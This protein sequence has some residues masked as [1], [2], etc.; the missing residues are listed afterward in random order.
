MPIV[1]YGESVFQSVRGI[2]LLDVIRRYCPG[3]E[4]RRQKR[5]YVGLCP[6]H[7]E[8]TPSFTISPDKNLFYCFGCGA[9]GDAV[10]FVVQLLRLSPLEAARQIAADFGL[11]PADGGTLSREAPEKLAEAR[12][13][14]KLERA[15]VERLEVEINRTHQAVCLLLR[16]ATATLARTLAQRDAETVEQLADL[17][18]LIPRL[19]WMA[20]KLYSPDAKERL[21]ALEKARLWIA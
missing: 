12:R 18:K 17:I 14:A 2:P 10:K 8:Q 13:R 20:D 1:A 11:L 6:F 5:E 21:T 9:G 4:L 3:L 16:T 7:Q 15:I 19:E